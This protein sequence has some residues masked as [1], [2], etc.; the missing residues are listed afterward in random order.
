M[1]ME[2]LDL[3]GVSLAEVFYADATGKMV[4][5][6]DRQALPIEAVETLILRARLR[7]PPKQKG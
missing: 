1:F 5:S 7:P 3:E 4:V 6:L 2:M